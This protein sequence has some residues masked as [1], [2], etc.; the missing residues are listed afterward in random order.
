MHPSNRRSRRFHRLL[1]SLT[2]I[3]LALT[4][5]SGALYGTVLSFN[6]DAPWLL[7]LHTGHFG[8]INLQPIDSPLIGVLTLILI[9]SG[10]PLL[11]RGRST[12]PSSAGNT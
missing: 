10:A 5:L 2:A 1:V 9:G 6:S 7:R 11:L 12:R 4:A 3:P 8:L